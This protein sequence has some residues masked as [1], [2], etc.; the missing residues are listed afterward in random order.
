[1]DLGKIQLG[2]DADVQLKIE[3]GKLIAVFEL[4]AA[5]ELSM[6]I[7]KLEAM[8]PGDQTGIAAAVKAIILSQL[9]K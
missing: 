3:G 2:S 5:K 9:S 4:D 8:I 1:M 7:D 6:L